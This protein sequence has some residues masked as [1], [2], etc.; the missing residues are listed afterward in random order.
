MRH[1]LVRPGGGSGPVWLGHAHLILFRF[2]A[3]ISIFPAK[4]SA[5][6]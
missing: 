5:V 6:S 2:I 4:L 3:H 1:E